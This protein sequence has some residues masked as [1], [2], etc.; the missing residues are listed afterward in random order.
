MRLL[1]VLRKTLRELRREKIMLVL[2]LVFAPFFVFIA[3]LIWA[4]WTTTFR[5]LVLDRD[6]AAAA[7][8]RERD[9]V[10]DALR[11]IRRADGTGV[12]DV[13]E[14]RDQASAEAELRERRS[15]V[16]L[17]VPPGF[18][19]AL[20]DGTP[21]AG[22]RAGPG[23]TVTLVGDLTNPAYAVAAVLTGAAVD[24]LVQEATGRPRPVTLEE[25]ALGVS[26]ARSDFELSVPGIMVFAVI[27][28]V[29]LSAMMI[30]RE[31]EAGTLRRLQITRMTAFDFLGGTSV[32]MVLVGVAG[33]LLTFLTAWVL[34]YR[35]QGPLWVAIAVGG[36][37]S[38]AIIGVGLVVACFSR[39]VAQAFVIANF[40]LGL[41]M[42][43][44]GTMFPVPRY[45]LFSIAGHGVSPFDALPPTHAVVA[46]NKVL[47]FG[48]GFADVTYELASL[49]VLSALYFGLGVWLFRRMR[50]RAA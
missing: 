45:E 15:A 35:S 13:A 26:G 23:P 27:L 10:L 48:A 1:A 37:T 31:T 42:F 46:L 24:A 5:V 2:T 4:N 16:L 21:P 34:G 7:T 29:F 33:V 40:P 17:V 20:G 25:H 38:I 6:R 50:L 28:M 39:T 18:R 22:Q 47:T 12:L 14:A 19:A 41:L 30:A 3:W 32:A 43:F 9:E 36:I 8:P 11:A 44:S 49:V